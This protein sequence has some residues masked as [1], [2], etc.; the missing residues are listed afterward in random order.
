MIVK[1]KNCGNEIEL[2]DEAIKNYYNYKCVCNEFIQLKGNF[3]H[4]W[5]CDKE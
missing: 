5:K 2:D 3:L 4:I 1:C